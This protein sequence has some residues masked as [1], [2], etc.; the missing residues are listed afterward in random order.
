MELLGDTIVIDGFEK[1]EPQKKIVVKKLAG[2]YAKEIEKKFSKTKKISILLR[3]HKPYYIEVNV[4]AGD[5]TMVVKST[6]KNLFYCMYFA[7][8]QLLKRQ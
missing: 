6:D 8:D 3:Q 2:I 7:F 5:N 4:I 1:L